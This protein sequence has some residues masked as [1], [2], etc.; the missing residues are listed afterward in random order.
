MNGD[1]RRRVKWLA[2]ITALSLLLCVVLVLGFF[3]TSCSFN[4]HIVAAGL[5]NP[6]RAF[7]TGT[8]YGVDVFIWDCYQSKHIVL[9]RESS[10]MRV[11][12]YMRQ[13]VAC[14]EQAPIELSL[15]DERKREL[16]PESFW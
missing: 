3:L 9:Y 14:G 12:P 1:S 13:E 6:D 8:V 7:Q 2:G 5:P 16:R 10:E 4:K 15:Q 11:G